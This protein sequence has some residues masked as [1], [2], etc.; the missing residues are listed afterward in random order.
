MNNNN[1]AKLKDKRRKNWFWDSNFVFGSNLSA[2]A[3]L[4]RLYLAKCSNDARQAWPSYNKI[5]KDC[6]ISR[7]TAKRA[8]SELEE[9]GW[10]EKKTQVKENGEYSS[11]ICFLCVPPEPEEE[12]QKDEEKPQDES[13]HG[14]GCS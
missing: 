9:K 8:V 7:D 6:G 5:A 2:H 13:G 4:I 14:G 1:V 12:P 11:N 10:V 3:K